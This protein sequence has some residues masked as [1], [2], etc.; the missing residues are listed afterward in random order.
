MDVALPKTFSNNVKKKLPENV[1]LRG[2]SR[3][4]WK[5]GLTTR[6]DTLYFTNGW[7][8]F[9]KD[10]S[11]KENDFLV[12]KYKGE[13]HFED[14]IFDG[15]SL[16]EKTA[17]FVGKCRPA[18]TE[19]GGSKAKDTASNGGVETPLVVPIGTN[20]G[21]TCNA[22]VESASPEKLTVDALTKTTTIQF[23]FQPTGKRAEKPVNEVTPVQTKKRGRPPTA[24][25]SCERA[26]SCQI[27]IT[28]VP[29]LDMTVPAVDQYG[30]FLADDMGLS[31]KYGEFRNNKREN[32]E[33]ARSESQVSILNRSGKDDDH[34]IPSSG[35]SLS[36]SSICHEKKIAQSYT[37]TF[38][39]FVKIIQKF[40]V[41][42]SCLLNIPSQF[43][44]AHIPNRII[45]IILHNLKGEQ[46]TVNAVNIDSNVYR[47]HSIRGGWIDFVRGNGIKVGN[48]CIFELMCENELSV[49]IAEVGKD[50]L[51]IQ[52]EKLDFSVPSARQDV[53]KR[54]QWQ[55]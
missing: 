37:S 12:F 28:A 4:V 9:V 13:S 30:G 32:D 40:N 8:Q 55:G 39:Y 48:V 19:Q 34:Y 36:R 46:W 5:V 16:C 2:P 47:Y 38:P 15:E 6:D 1:T 53:R 21:K 54:R 23:P 33:V 26:H 10:H 44:K 11:L 24:G 27:S 43:S 50:G 29:Y 7:Q 45:K 17:Y 25:N 14:L 41:G 35:A 51:D 20:N 49:R 3:V 22:G 31:P 42:G 18:Q 52:D